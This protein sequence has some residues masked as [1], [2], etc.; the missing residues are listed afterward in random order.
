[1]LRAPPALMAPPAS[2][3]PPALA[4]KLAAL[5]APPRGA[6]AALKRAQLPLLQLE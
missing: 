3:A 2:G 1:M 4:V 6:L 5:S